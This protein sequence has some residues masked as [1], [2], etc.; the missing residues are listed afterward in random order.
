MATLAAGTVL[1]ALC[2]LFVFIVSFQGNGPCCARDGD[3]PAVE[4]ARIGVATCEGPHV[5]ASVP[6]LH[7]RGGMVDVD[8]RFEEVAGQ[9][10]WPEAL[11]VHTANDTYEAFANDDSWAVLPAHDEHLARYRD[12]LPREEAWLAFSVLYIAKDGPVRGAFQMRC[13]IG[14]DGLP[15]ARIVP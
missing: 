4:G 8:V 11:R 3:P 2:A 1:L 7:A 12:V 13:D 15:A 10:W 5:R 9:A 14:A 6:R